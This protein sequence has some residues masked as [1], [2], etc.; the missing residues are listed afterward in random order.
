MCRHQ[1]AFLLRPQVIPIAEDKFALLEAYN[2][3]LDELSVVDLKFLHTPSSVLPPTSAI[4]CLLN[5]SHNHNHSRCIR[6]VSRRGGQ[7]GD[8]PLASCNA[9]LR[10]P[11]SACCRLLPVLRPAHVC[12]S[13]SI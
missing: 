10:L 2:I 11:G 3:R 7:L 6:S 9:L 1:M 13:F 5:S 4:T 12:G 8:S